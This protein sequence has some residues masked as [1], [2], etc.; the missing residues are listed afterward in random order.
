MRT[1]WNSLEILNSEL[2]AMDAAGLS[3]AEGLQEASHQARK[4]A[5]REAVR[6]AATAAENGVPVSEALRKNPRVFPE[7]YVSL[8]AAAEAGGDMPTVLRGM[9]QFIELRRRMVASMRAALTYPALVLTL[10]VIVSIFVTYWII[11]GFLDSIR[12]LHLLVPRE[13]ILFPRQ[14]AFALDLQQVLVVVLVIVWIAAVAVTLMGVVAP[15]SRGTHGFLLKVPFYGRVFRNYLIYHLSGVLGMLLRQRVPMDTALEN[16]GSL[17]ESP[18]LSDAAE[19]GLR[20]V[21]NGELLSRGLAQVPWLPKSE[22]WLMETAEQQEQLE[23]YLEELNR[24]TASSIAR[25]ELIFKN[26]EPN[27]V[28]LLAIGIGAY[29]ISVFIPLFNMFKFMTLGE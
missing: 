20:A 25:S 19:H 11:P 15:A 2:V 18:L 8:V 21:R 5:F 3:L 22:L 6:S 28:A 24:R 12:A 27:L 16:L 13:S 23:S 4:G 17:R 26:I 10:A 7:L 1:D 29:I 14:V 9:A